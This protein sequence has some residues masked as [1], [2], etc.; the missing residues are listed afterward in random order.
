MFCLLYQKQN[1]VRFFFFASSWGSYKI[2][3]NIQF[4]REL[5]KNATIENNIN[6]SNNNSEYTVRNR[7]NR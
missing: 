1:F 2:H 5:L 3:D 6:D 4:T 7:M